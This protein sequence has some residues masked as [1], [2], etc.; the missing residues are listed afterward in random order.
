[1]NEVVYDLAL[2]GLAFLL[3]GPRAMSAYL[4]AMTV[5]YIAKTVYLFVKNRGK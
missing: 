2:A 5:Y 1:M 4:M 3:F